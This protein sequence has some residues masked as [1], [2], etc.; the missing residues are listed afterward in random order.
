MRASGVGAIAH[1]RKCVNIVLVPKVDTRR[2]HR[3][4]ALA[5]A[6]LGRVSCVQTNLQR[7]TPKIMFSE[8]YDHY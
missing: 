2:Q 1:A 6:G 8:L 3:V 4:A 7:T 5:G